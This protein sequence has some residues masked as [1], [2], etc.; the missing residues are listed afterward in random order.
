MLDNISFSRMHAPSNPVIPIQWSS[1][2][3]NTI[4]NILYAVQQRNN[5]ELNRLVVAEEKDHVPNR[6]DEEERERV[7]KKRFSKI[8]KYKKK[9]HE[10]STNTYTRDT[11]IV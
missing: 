6:M 3:V 1:K 4:K 2:N 5:P 10:R 8:V 9:A 11:T 7:K